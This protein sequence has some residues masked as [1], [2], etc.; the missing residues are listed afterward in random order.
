MCMLA[1]HDCSTPTAD[2]HGPGNQISCKFRN[3]SMHLHHS[4]DKHIYT[5]VLTHSFT[6]TRS[7]CIVSHTQ[8]FGR[9]Y[10]TRMD[11]IV[12]VRRHPTFCFCRRRWREVQGRRTCLARRWIVQVLDSAAFHSP[13]AHVRPADPRFCVLFAARSDASASCVFS[14][15][16]LRM[17]GYGVRHTSAR[18]NKH[19]SIKNKN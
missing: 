11:R 10:S 6:G 4:Y 19:N 16:A 3:E 15:G 1:R 7:V 18:P 17:A 8:G 9:D 13:G 2:D 5:G 14:G 12:A